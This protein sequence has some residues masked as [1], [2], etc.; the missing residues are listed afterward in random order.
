MPPKQKV[1]VRIDD[2]NLDVAIR[3]FAHWRKQRSDAEKLE[4]EAKE[5][6][7]KGVSGYHQEHGA[8]LYR[9]SD[10]VA[11][12]I[13]DNAG[14]SRIDGEVL[15]MSGVSPEIIAKATNRSPFYVYTPNVTAPPGQSTSGA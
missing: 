6:L 15:L 2:P 8:D 10:N 7:V 3:T 4:K 11:V 13:S 5:I 14:Q 12:A 9:T 1:E